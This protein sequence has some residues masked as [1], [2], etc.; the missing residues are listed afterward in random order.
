V[1]EA[2][3]QTLLIRLKELRS[4]R[5]TLSRSESFF[6]NDLPFYLSHAP[7]GTADY[8]ISHVL[9][10][11]LTN[12]DYSVRQQCLVAETLSSLAI[13]RRTFSKL[14]VDSLVQATNGPQL[15]VQ[16]RCASA[17][18]LIRFLL[19]S[20]RS[21][22]GEELFDE[23]F[24]TIRNFLLLP[25]GDKQGDA[26]LFMQADS[27]LWEI[28]ESRRWKERGD[29]VWSVVEEVLTTPGLNKNAYSA[30]SHCLELG[31]NAVRRPK[32]VNISRSVRRKVLESLTAQSDTASIE[33]LIQNINY[34]LKHNSSK[35]NLDD[36]LLLEKI[37]T[38]RG[39]KRE[40]YS[41]AINQLAV[42]NI[43]NEKLISKVNHCFDRILRTQGL[44]PAVHQFPL[45]PSQ[46]SDLSA[47]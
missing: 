27:L 5:S 41:K 32:L 2:V 16:S 9:T 44:D 29:N 8:F 47:P 45:Q 25:K 22:E 18:Q 42:L 4:S 1:E 43:V 36:V 3:E 31:Q 21:P 19:K 34:L 11:I 10:P 46:S 35:I 37:I 33:A 15:S 13:Q 39:L 24:Q 40:I 28:A 6:R 17:F 38:T 12:P 20:P 7:I 26:F 23:A 14:P 30:A